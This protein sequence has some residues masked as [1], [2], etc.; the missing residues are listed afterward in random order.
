MYFNNNYK[1]LLFYP[2]TLQMRGTWVLQEVH[3][4]EQPA[5]AREEPQQGGA[6]PVQGA[7]GA[8]QGGE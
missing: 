5:E 8:H 2:E 1:T 3:G 7:A 4:P 6:G